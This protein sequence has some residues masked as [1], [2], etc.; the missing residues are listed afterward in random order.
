MRKRQTDGDLQDVGKGVSVDVEAT[1]DPIRV[2]RKGD[3]AVDEVWDVFPDD[4]IEHDGL[5]DGLV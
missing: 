5:P 1:V 2:G 4:G 3:R